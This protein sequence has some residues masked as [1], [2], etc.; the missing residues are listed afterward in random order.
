MNE[1]VGAL[2]HP[3]FELE[4]VFDEFQM[5]KMAGE[6]G[7]KCEEVASLIS[8]SL[9]GIRQIEELLKSFRRFYKHEKSLTAVDLIPVIEDVR[10]LVIYNL[11]RHRIQFLIENRLPEPL[12]VWGNRQEL[13]QAVTNIV[14]N[15]ADAFEGTAIQQRTIV[16]RLEYA[17]EMIVLTVANNGP[18]IFEEIA[19]KVFEPFF[20]TKSG[21]RGTGLGLSIVR[22]IMRG[23]GGDVV[24]RNKENGSDFV[25]FVCTMPVYRERRKTRIPS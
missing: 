15:A 1:H 19:D 14:N 20:T 9:Q 11:R 25:E 10:T 2:L 7:K 18:K 23:M 16:V 6:E 13:I 8:D 21:E 24:L 4:L 3:F 22:Q 5:V 17:N 12:A